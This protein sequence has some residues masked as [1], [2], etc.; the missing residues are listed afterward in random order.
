VATQP[1]QP[2]DGEHDR[3]DDQ[4]DQGVADTAA[5]ADLDRPSGGKSARRTERNWRR[6]TGVEV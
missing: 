4:P 2:G 6:L 3:G 1:G 5:P